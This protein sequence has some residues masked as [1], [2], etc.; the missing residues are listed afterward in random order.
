MKWY[1]VILDE[2]HYIKN[3]RSEIA[4]A[5][6]HL[7]AINRWCLTASPIQNNFEDLYS[8]LKFLQVDYLS[9][10]HRLWNA[11]LK[12]NENFLEIFKHFVT[13]LLLRRSEQ[14]L[15]EN[16]MKLLRK[17]PKKIVKIIKIDMDPDHYRLYTALYLRLVRIN[18]YYT[19]KIVT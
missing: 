15:D 12:K 5:C 3:H 4:E 11:F 1:R 16:S 7:K 10:N 13:P 2:A 6:F 17:I 19:N 9:E 8:L 14:C 18:F